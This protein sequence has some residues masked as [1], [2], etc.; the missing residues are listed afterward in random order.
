[1]QKNSL[2]QMIAD[3][4]RH[5][6]IRKLVAVFLTLLLYV[7]IGQ[8]TSERREKFFHEIPVH[9]ELPANLALSNNDCSFHSQTTEGKCSE[10]IA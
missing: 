4:V 8:R 2:W 1:M 9:L 6:T 10:R 7:A 5:D 3:F